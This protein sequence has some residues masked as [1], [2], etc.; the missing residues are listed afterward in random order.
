MRRPSRGWGVALGAVVSIAAL[1][2]GA[3]ESDARAARPRSRPR[4]RIVSSNVD[5][6]AD[7]QLNQRIELRFDGRVSGR[8]L[9]DGSIEVVECDCDVRSGTARGDV[10]GPRPGT[11][12]RRGRKLIFTPRLPTNLRDPDDP[13]GDFPRIVD[14]YGDALRNGTFF[15]ARSYAVL[16]HGVD[17][18]KPF[19]VAGRA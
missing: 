7:V 14:P 4:L 17:S 16:L 1:L 13:D 9:T 11:F 19:R 6:F 10:Y 5:F 8:S 3:G 18:G 12:T 2:S 15:P